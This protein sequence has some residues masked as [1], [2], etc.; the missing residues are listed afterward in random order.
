M[1]NGKRINDYVSSY[2]VFDLETTGISPKNDKII[3]ISSVKVKDGKIIDEFSTLVNP[4]IPIPFYATEVNNIT[5]KMVKDAPSIEEALKEFVS[6]V[7]DYVLIGHN[8]HQFD[9]K[10]IYR[11][12]NDCFGKGME[13]DY[14]DTLFMARRALPDLS[15]HTLQDLAEYYGV[16]TEGAHRAL[17]DCKMNQIVYENLAEELKKSSAKIDKD[18]I[19]PVCSSQLVKRNGKF[20]EFIGCKGY[21]QCRYTRNL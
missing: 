20:G 18:M 6:F 7:G 14:L 16:S 17:F 2:C 11:E 1:P 4:G 9:M 21:P 3:E 10:F 12:M 15:H 19:C 8:I 5:D 13:N